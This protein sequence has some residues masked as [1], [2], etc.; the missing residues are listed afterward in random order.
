M[1]LIANT[2]LIILLILL[3]IYTALGSFAKPYMYVSMHYLFRLGEFLYEVCILWMTQKM[4]P[5]TT[6]DPTSSPD[7]T[8]FETTASTNNS[9]AISI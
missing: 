5:E 3:V 6:P 9:N 2:I 1:V 8:V 4:R 7:L